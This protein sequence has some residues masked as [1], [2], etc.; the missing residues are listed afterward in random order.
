MVDEVV[1]LLGRIEPGGQE[2]GEW[3]VTECQWRSRTYFPCGTL[4]FGTEGFLPKMPAE[5][6][7][8]SQKEGTRATP[9]DSLSPNDIHSETKRVLHC[10]RLALWG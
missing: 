8:P 5:V 3:A 4:L 9:T 2:Q 7:H 6:Q 1:V 10:V